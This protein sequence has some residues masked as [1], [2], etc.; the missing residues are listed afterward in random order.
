MIERSHISRMAAILF[1]AFATGCASGPIVLHPKAEVDS[2]QCP[3]HRPTFRLVRVWDKR[4]YPDTRNVGFTQTGLSNTR[5]A[6]MTDRPT[7]RVM[8]DTLSAAMQRCGML[9]NSASAQPLSVDLLAMQINEQTGLVSETMTGQVRYEIVALDPNGGRA[10]DRFQ[11]TGQSQHSSMDTTDFAEET[12]NESIGS[13]LPSFLRQL[14]TLREPLG[15]AE[16]N[17]DD[18]TSPVRV[19]VRGLNEQEERERFGRLMTLRNF[20]VLAVEIDLERTGSIGHPLRIRRQDFRLTFDSGLRRFALDPGKL[21]V[22][23]LGVSTGSLPIYSGSQGTSLSPQSIGNTLEQ[24]D[25]SFDAREL[26][27]TL[28][29]ELLDGPG[30]PVQ[31]DVSYEDVLTHEIHSVTVPYEQPHTVGD[32][33]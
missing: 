7:G 17:E 23:R 3:A 10:L 31:M 5:T 11:V 32:P 21:V 27:T 14:A 2:S 20:R 8:L 19:R 1:A 16:A 33:R 15:A 9:A 6:L 18:A 4:G 12:L 25:L 24:A 28:L 26:R 29:F 13:S 30:Q 22:E